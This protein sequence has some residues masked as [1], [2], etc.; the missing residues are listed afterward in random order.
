MQIEQRSDEKETHTVL[1]WRSALEPP[2][3]R[4]RSYTTL[5]SP[6]SVTESS[7][8]SSSSNTTPFF[9]RSIEFSSSMKTLDDDDDV[10]LMFVLVIK[11]LGNL[12]HAFRCLLVIFTQLGAVLG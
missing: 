7:G 6:P 8:H 2:Q 5:G 12:K 9:I 10:Q 1:T 3:R 11:L 4:R